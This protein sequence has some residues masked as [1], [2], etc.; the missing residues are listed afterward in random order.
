VNLVYL[1]ALSQ[2]LHDGKDFCQRLLQPFA[3]G[4]AGF[5]LSMVRYV[6]NAQQ[7]SGALLGIKGL[8]TLYPCAAF[9]I[10]AANRLIC[11]NV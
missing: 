10:A 3:G 2:V 5:G 6:A 9:L 4:L 11:T 7:T 8:Q 1:P